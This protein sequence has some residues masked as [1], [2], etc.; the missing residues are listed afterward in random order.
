MEEKFKKMKI[1]SGIILIAYLSFVQGVIMNCKYETRNSN[2]LGTTY[3]CWATSL[4]SENLKMI[5]EL[6]GQHLSGKSN[7][8]VGIF[9]ETNKKL[10]YIPTNFVD[11]FPNLKDISF[12]APL[13]SLTSADL[14]PFPNLLSFTSGHGEFRSIEGDLFKYTRK[15]E[16]IQFMYGHLEH[17]GENLLSGLYDLS[18][19]DFY[20]NTCI[21]LTANTPTKIEELKEK[22]LLRCPAVVATTTTSSTTTSMPTTPSSTTLPITSTLSMSTTQCSNRC[23]LGIEFDQQVDQQ[24]YINSLLDQKLL[25]Q[26]NRIVEL[27]MQIREI[28]SRL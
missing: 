8:D 27:E 22:L 19:A 14:K 28:N 16:S 9:I 26:E 23:S 2:L 3:I 25:I 13:L 6:H 17:V 12:S 18:Q 10:K 20:V 7:A 4:N 5:T 11:Y 15:L 1:V 24:S 21:S